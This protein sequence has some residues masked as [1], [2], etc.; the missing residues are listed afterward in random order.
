MEILRKIYAYLV[1]TVQTFLLAAAVFLF[2]YL[3]IARPFQVSGDSMYPTYKDREYI[4][5]NIVGVKLKHF[6]RGDVIVFK[7]PVDQSKDFI[8]RIIGLP[9]EQIML[10][11][12]SVYI[13]GRNLDE[14]AYLSPDVR[15][16]GREF[17]AEG[18]TITVPQGEVFVMGD[19]R[20]YSSDS[21]DWGFLK[22]SDI[23][24]KSF[25]VYWPVNDA[26]FVHNPFQK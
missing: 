10:K 17:L 15:T 20:Q 22:E 16:D 3:V 21:R 25:F 6:N 24:G 18:Q 9:G 4:F 14:S 13:N 1:D 19:N 23:I 11:D 5:T 7:A 8:K 12:G 2:I 26:H